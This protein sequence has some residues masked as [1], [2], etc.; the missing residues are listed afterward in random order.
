MEKP[1][2][3]QWN[4]DK[5]N[6]EEEFLVFKPCR[7]ATAGKP[8]RAFKKGETVSLKGGVK[9]DL[10]FQNKILYPKDFEAVVKYEAEQKEKF[11]MEA[12]ATVSE[13]SLN[14]KGKGK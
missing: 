6:E 1:R 4:Q 5:I 11:Q 10:Y 9:K 7:I 12:S 13:K 3:T 2:I 8:A 14:G